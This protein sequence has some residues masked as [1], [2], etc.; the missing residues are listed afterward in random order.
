MVYLGA[1]ASTGFSLLF[2]ET[3]YFDDIR[4]IFITHTLYPLPI[5]L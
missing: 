2:I 5:S 3:N 4:E 1:K